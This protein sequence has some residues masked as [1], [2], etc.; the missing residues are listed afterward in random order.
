MRVVE[1]PPIHRT[2]FYTIKSEKETAITFSLLCAPGLFLRINSSSNPVCGLDSLTLF[3]SFCSDRQNSFLTPITTSKIV[4]TPD[5]SSL[6]LQRKKSSIRADNTG[7]GFHEIKRICRD[8]KIQ[9]PRPGFSNLKLD[10]DL[11][12]AN[13]AV[14]H[15]SHLPGDDG[16][17]GACR[18]RRADGP[19]GRWSHFR[20]SDGHPDCR[21]GRS[22]NRKTAARGLNENRDD[23]APGLW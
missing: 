23:R 20:R 2:R 18:Q 9:A 13:P 12:L 22:R 8:E 1:F 17:V 19:A 7:H 6:I 14:Q 3:L 16:A 15:V 4:R 10:S 5:R 21:R 11:R